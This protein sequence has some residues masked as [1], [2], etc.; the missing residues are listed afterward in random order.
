M[1]LEDYFEALPELAPDEDESVNLRLLRQG[2]EAFNQATLKLQTYY[3]GLETKVDELNHE[4][5]QKNKEL[6][7]NLQEKERVKNYLSN[8]LESSAIGIIVTDLDGIITSVNQT[9]L[10]LLA[11]SSEALSGQRL[12][13]IFHAQILPWDPTLEN[14]KVYEKVKEQELDF[15]RKNGSKIQLLFSIS[16]MYSEFGDILGLIVNV[17]DITELK[18]LEAQAERKNRFTVM[19]EMAA[20][21]AHEIR[22]PL[23]SI[24][25]FASLLKKDLPADSSKQALLSHITS[26]IHSMNHIISNILEYTKPHLAFTKDIIEI[27]Q[28]LYDVLDVSQYLAKPNHVQ[29]CEKFEAIETYV[30]GDKELLKQVFFN[31]MNNAVQA[32]LESGSVTVSTRNIHANNEK[33][34]RRFREFL[35]PAESLHLIEIRIQDTGLGMSPEVKK[36]IFDPFFTTKERGT[37][38]GLAIVH[39]IVEAHNALIDVESEVDQGTQFTLLFPVLSENDVT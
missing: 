32:I 22:N 10:T 8:I 1:S 27:H 15:Q 25:L 26:A 12:N 19:G 23:G 14:L 35:G 31:L 37:G 20:T 4:L 2:F 9:G 16:L 29:I 33:L 28:F 6:E 17:Q 11:E 24:E 39:N 30:A 18:K 3:R 5:A 7:T 38:L 21:I 36:K 34:L 13:D